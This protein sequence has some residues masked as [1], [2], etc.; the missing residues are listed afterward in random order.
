M[1]ALNTADETIYSE[2]FTKK[3]LA[4]GTRG[5]YRVSAEDFKDFVG[6][7]LSEIIDKAEEEE[8]SGIRLRKRSVNKYL[9]GYKAYLEEK[10]YAPGTLNN[11]MAAILSL[12]QAFDIQVPKINLPKGDISLEKNFK[13]PPTRKQIQT[14]ISVANARDRALIYFLALTGTASN[15]ARNLTVKNFLDAAGE[16]IGKKI[17]DLDKLFEYED[18]ILKEV[19]TLTMVRQ[20][21]NYRYQTFIPPEASH[22]IISYLK[23]RKFN[24][25]PN[26]HVKDIDGYL[27]ITNTGDPMSRTGVGTAIKRVGK[28]AGFESESGSFCFWRPHSLRKYFISAIS[29]HLGDHILADYLVG[30]KISNV[31]RAYWIMEP[32]VL[33][34]R[35]L[36]ALPYLSIDKVRVTDVETREFK[37]IQKQNKALKEEIDAIKSKISVLGD[38][39]RVIN[40]PVVREALNEELDK[41]G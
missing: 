41:K 17:S 39:S 36:K 7:S 11:K 5:T 25:N 35:Y 6:L 38:F 27:F 1:A 15:E 2:W 9:I 34:E 23:E 8:E 28:L 22:A 40:N 20:K 37:N 18:E 30:H 29:N 19:L 3:N 33:K 31:R 21:V 16:A 4:K 13:K 24:R 12:F 32:E 14:M 26:R 10:N